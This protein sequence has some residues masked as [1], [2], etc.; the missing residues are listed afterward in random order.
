MKL[1]RAG[2]IIRRRHTKSK[3]YQTFSF[4]FKFCAF[5]KYVPFFRLVEMYFIIPGLLECILYEFV[6]IV[7]LQ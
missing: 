4:Y 7:R 2:S 3:T 6:H 1:N 5:C